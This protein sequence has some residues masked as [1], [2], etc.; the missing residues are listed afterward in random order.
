MEEDPAGSVLAGGA[1]SKLA[2]KLD[3]LQMRSQGRRGHRPIPW[4]VKSVLIP[5]IKQNLESMMAIIQD[6][7]DD[8]S[9]RAAIR[10]LTKEVRELSYDIHDCIDEHT[11]GPASDHATRLLW[12]MERHVRVAKG[13]D[14]RRRSTVLLAPRRT[15]RKPV[16]SCWLSERLK[17]RL[18]LLDKMREFRARSEEALHRYMSFHPPPTELPPPK[19]Q[20]NDHNYGDG[21]TSASATRSVESFGSWSP[22]PYTHVLHRPVGIHDLAMNTLKAWLTDGDSPKLK[23]VSMVGCG[24][25]G[26]TTL[27]NELYRGIGG[28]FEYRA[29]VRTSQKTDV[30]SLLISILS[31]IQPRQPPGNWKVHD[32][33]GNIR[34]HLQDKRYLIVIDDVWAR[35]TWDIVNRAFPDGNHCSRILITSELEDVALKCCGYEPQYV[36]KMKP[37][38]QDDSTQLFYSIDGCSQE[39]SEVSNSIIRKCGGLPLAIVTIASLLESR[40]GKPEQREYVDKS[41]GYG[42]MTNP[43]FEGM[44]QVVNLSYRNLPQHLKACLLY[45]CIFPE[46]YIIWTD[47][48]V[49]QWIAEGFICASE[50]KDEEEISR[51]YFDELISSRLIHPINIDGNGKVLSCTMHPMM[52]SHIMHESL[53]ENFVAAIDDSQIATRFTHKVRRLSLQFGNAEDA[54]LSTNMRLSQVRTLAFFGAFKCVPSITEFRLLQVLIL[55]FWGEEEIMRFDLTSISEIFRLRYLQVTCNVTLEIQ[56]TQ[57]LRRLQYL[58]TLKIDAATGSRILSDSIHSP[59]LL[60]LRLPAGTNLLTGVGHMTSLRTLGHFDLITNSIDNVQDLGELINVQDLHLTCTPVG[61]SSYLVKVVKQME[62]LSSVLEKLNNLK[63]LTLKNSRLVDG[64]PSSMSISCDVLNSVSSPPALLQRLEWLPRACTFSSIP[65]WIGHLGKLC[66]LKIGVRALVRNDVDLL[67]KLPALTYLSLYVR[68]KPAEIIVFSGGGFLVLTYFGFRCSV[69]CL[70]FEAGVMPN[71]QKLKLGFD[72]HGAIQYSPII[73]GLDHLSGLE[74][75]S[76][77]LGGKFEAAV[78]P[79][80]QKLKQCFGA[81]EAIQYGPIPAGLDQ[82]PGLKEISAKIGGASDNEPVRRIVESALSDAVKMHPGRPTVN[83]QC[84]DQKFGDSDDQGSREDAASRYVFALLT[85]T[86]VFYSCLCVLLI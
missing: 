75:I 81:H 78:M 13:N 9:S 76:A 18:W 60:H 4:E 65:E 38:S 35:S 10:C 63:C 46:D 74:E 40:M 56:Q 47:D 64:R 20:R 37:L 80:L 62:C 29:F 55:H 28:Q 30:R 6:D 19:K 59:R 39:L 82:L 15:S 86:A 54:T 53:V 16:T 17:G 67:K 5:V 8:N 52:R 12:R 79:T 31:Q 25:V 51:S 33:I 68:T 84:V 44:K 72:A 24:G 83:I 66:I 26:K 61:P 34:T 1:M 71:L 57:M 41:L 45:L 36:Y 48:L 73:A 7:G 2:A 14:K 3:G 69:P 27:A 23:V 77:K 22:L 50:N 32:L 85:V 49:K 70:K 42:L 58:E 43:T 21:S 11:A